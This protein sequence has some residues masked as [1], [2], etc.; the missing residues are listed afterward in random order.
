MKFSEEVK[1][2]ARAIHRLTC[3]GNHTDWCDFFYNK[4]SREFDYKNAKDKLKS[5]KENQ[6]TP[7]QLNTIA[8][9]LRPHTKDWH[10]YDRETPKT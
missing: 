3:N 2:Y 9:I 1:E 10:K 7:Q 4:E 6:I 5:L 8:D